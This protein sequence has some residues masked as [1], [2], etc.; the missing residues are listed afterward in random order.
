[1]NLQQFAEKHKTLTP[2]IFWGF[3]ILLIIFLVTARDTKPNLNSPNN[4]TS[5]KNTSDCLMEKMTLESLKQLASK[6]NIGVT[7]KDIDWV[8]QKPLCRDICIEQIKYAKE[9]P[10][11]WYADKDIRAICNNV[12]LPLP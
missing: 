1:M 6:E 3:W 8:N 2:I 4:I 10:S 11:E 12:G 5:D 9:Y 7:Q